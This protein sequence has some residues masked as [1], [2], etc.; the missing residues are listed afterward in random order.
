MTPAP[1]TPTQLQRL[2][3]LHNRQT[4][5]EVAAIKGDRKV[6]IAYA[7]RR[8]LAGLVACFRSRTEKIVRGLD[9]PEYELPCY[10][11]KAS[12]GILFFGWQICFTG[13][14]ERECIMSAELPYVGDLADE[15]ERMA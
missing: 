8:S 9:I 1:L 5:Y 12:D 10:I 2:A 7:G 13:R 15:L 3:R 14:T 11:G 6:L 4:L